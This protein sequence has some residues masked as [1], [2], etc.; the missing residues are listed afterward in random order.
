[1]RWEGEA[2]GSLLSSTSPSFL[3]PS[4]VAHGLVPPTFRVDLLTPLKPLWEDFSTP[5]EVCLLS[6]SSQVGIEG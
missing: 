6:G 3:Q 2:S 5:L 4:T 1:M